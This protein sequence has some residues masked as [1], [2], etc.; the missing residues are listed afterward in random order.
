MALNRR[1]RTSQRRTQILVLQKVNNK[2]YHMTCLKTDEYEE[3]TRRRKQR[4]K[5]NTLQQMQEHVTTE[6]SIEIGQ[7][8]KY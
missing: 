2:V 7:I 4:K 3:L 1:I 5:I 6:A 8:E